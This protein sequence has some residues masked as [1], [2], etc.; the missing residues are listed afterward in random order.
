MP[1]FE[2]VLARLRVEV[3]KCLSFARRH[4]RTVRQSGIPPARQMV[5]NS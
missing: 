2:L 1:T 4:D 3:A 5:L